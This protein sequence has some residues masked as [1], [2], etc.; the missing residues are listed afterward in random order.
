MRLSQIVQAEINITTRYTRLKEIVRD[1][2]RDN[3]GD[4]L[5]QMVAEDPDKKQDAEKLLKQLNQGKDPA[6]IADE[7]DDLYR[8]W[9]A[10]AK[11]DLPGVKKKIGTETR[12][13][14]RGARDPFFKGTKAQNRIIDFV[15]SKVDSWIMTLPKTVFVFKEYEAALFYTITGDEEVLFGHV[16]FRQDNSRFRRYR[17]YVTC[18]RADLS[19]AKDQTKRQLLIRQSNLTK[20]ERHQLPGE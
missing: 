16:W 5:V 11:R 3:V 4:F 18:E 14:I 19:K 7:I 6:K 12:R 8:K 2:D 13:A 9:K 10:N 15:Q 20:T 1:P 17:Y